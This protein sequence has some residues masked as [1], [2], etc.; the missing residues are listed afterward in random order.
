MNPSRAE[1]A[2]T[3]DPP[4]VAVIFTSIRAGEEDD[5]Y[6]TT[7]TAMS[8][9][10]TRQPGYLGVDSAREQIGITVSY[11]RDEASARSWKQV[12]GH[13]VAQRRGRERWYSDYRVHIAHVVRA[14]GPHD[15]A[16]D[17]VPD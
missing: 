2:G 15:D 5:G 13:T 4:Y 1:L 11:W 10:A 3:P 17:G 8:R 6:S 9:L 12:A 16:R 14:Y 7:D